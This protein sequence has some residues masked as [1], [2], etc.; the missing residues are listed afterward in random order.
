M[1]RKPGANFYSYFNHL[2]QPYFF[3]EDVILV[4]AVKS[5]GA[6]IRNSAFKL[7]DD[8]STLGLSV[9]AG[10]EYNYAGGGWTYG[11]IF[12][13]KFVDETHFLEHNN[14]R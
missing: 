7:T 1:C 4:Q 5:P 2:N 3:T 8:G 13:L 11:S 10:R 14:F 6:G 12:T 9:I